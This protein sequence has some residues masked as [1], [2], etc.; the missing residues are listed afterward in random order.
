MFDASIRKES[1]VQPGF[2]IGFGLADADA[3]AA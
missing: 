3:D 2:G 1:Q